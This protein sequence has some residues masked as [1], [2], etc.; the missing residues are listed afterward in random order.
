[1]IKKY[2][3]GRI[4]GGPGADARKAGARK[5]RT[6][7]GPGGVIFASGDET[8]RTGYNCKGDR[9]RVSPC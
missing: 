6:P 2:P 8:H 7:V 3:D 9:S 5:E 4:L 1:M